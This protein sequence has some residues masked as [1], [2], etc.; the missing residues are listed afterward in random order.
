MYKADGLVQQLV[1]IGGEAS[2]THLV[3]MDVLARLARSRELRSALFRVAGVCDVAARPLERPTVGD[4]RPLMSLALNLAVDDEEA[5]AHFCSRPGFVSKLLGVLADPEALAFCGKLLFRIT[6]S[7]RNQPWPQTTPSS[8]PAALAPC[9]CSSAR[10]RPCRSRATACSSPCS[11]SWPASVVIRRLPGPTLRAAPPRFCVADPP[12][13][14]DH[15]V[16][17][18][19]INPIALIS[20]PR[21]SSPSPSSSTLSAAPQ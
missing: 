21:A 11:L 16:P 20:S 9:S 1:R 12:H 4:E 7:R 5:Q 17:V 3:A 13:F 18:L 2:R 10:W 15:P 8:P 19:I 14:I 6:E